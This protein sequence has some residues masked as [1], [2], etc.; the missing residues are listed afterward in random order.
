MFLVSHL[1]LKLPQFEPQTNLELWT[2][3]SN[4]FGSRGSYENCSY[5]QR[6]PCYRKPISRKY[7][8][9]LNSCS[10]AGAWFWMP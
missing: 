10:D 7:I 3:T 2:R 6:K 5:M 9:V 8:I 1:A 4:R